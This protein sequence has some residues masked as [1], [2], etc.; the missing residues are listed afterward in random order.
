M[1][2]LDNLTDHQ[3]KT[4][5][6]L[7]Y[8]VGLWVGRSDT[9]GGNQSDQMELQALS[10]IIHG[11][12][13]EIFGAES[14]QYIMSEAIMNKDQWPDWEKNLETVPEDCRFA[15]DVMQEH[16]SIKEASAFRIQL[17]EIGEAVALAFTEYQMP[18]S[19]LRIVPLY[20]S[21]F[22]S[23]LKKARR[24]TFDE[25]LS[26]SAQERKALHQIAQALGTTYS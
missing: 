23:Q 18:D 12:A 26:I 5:V 11:F 16:T 8:R 1:S 17:M 9:T 25:F 24:R 14:I 6:S 4:L 7:P 3:R 2:F 22:L 15:M 20:I 21:Y 13:E 10:G 19:P